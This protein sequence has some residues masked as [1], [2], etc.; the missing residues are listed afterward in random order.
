ME[1]TTVEKKCFACQSQN[2]RHGS[3]GMTRHTF[4]PTNKKMWSGYTVL[5]FVCLDCGNVGYYVGDS[6]ILELR[7]LDNA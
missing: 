7:K 1:T 2:L 6:D 4:L 3:I 5:A